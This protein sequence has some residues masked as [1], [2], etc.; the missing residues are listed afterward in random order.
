MLQAAHASIDAFDD[1]RFIRVEL[2]YADTVET[3]NGTPHDPKPTQQTQNTF[4]YKTRE[5]LL[6]WGN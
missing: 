5:Q 4:E 6:L 2:I 3:L 1:K